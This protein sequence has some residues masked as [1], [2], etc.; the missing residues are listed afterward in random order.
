MKILLIRAFG[1]FALFHL[2][3][4]N[5]YSQEGTVALNQP[6]SA[7]F[8][9][10]RI[11]LAPVLLGNTPN[12]MQFGGSIYLRVYLNKYVSFDTDLCLSR[13][14]LHLGPGI[15][16]LP[17]AMLFLSSSSDLGD[18]DEGTE[19]SRDGFVSFLIRVTLVLLS[20]EH[21]SAHIPVYQDLEISPYVSFLRYRFQSTYSGEMPVN[22]VPEQFCFAAGL[23]IDKSFGRFVLSPFIE[24]NIGYRDK[25]SGYMAGLECSMRFSLT[26][27]LSFR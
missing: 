4:L 1:L 5:S 21:M 23:S 9:D 7:E 17:I 12:G 22:R 6:Y 15:F 26:R 24:Y 3:F 27:K 19:L 20:V 16:G 10:F 8:G 18:D 2:I 14:Y 25:I 13:D 11:G